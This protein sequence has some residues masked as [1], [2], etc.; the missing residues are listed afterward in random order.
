MALVLGAVLPY[1]LLV[2]RNLYDYLYLQNAGALHHV[3]AFKGSL[4]SA[5]TYYLTG[6]SGETMLG[7]ALYMAVALIALR[8]AFLPRDDAAARWRF[9]ALMLLTAF[10][11]ALPTWLTNKTL[12]VGSP[13]Q[14][15]VVVIAVMCLYALL[16]RL[17]S[18]WFEIA[19][20][21]AVLLT[22]EFPQPLDRR[23]TP[24]VVA[25]NDIMQGLLAALQAQDLKPGEP[26]FLTSTGYVSAN[27]LFYEFSKL[28]LPMP[29]FYELSLSDDASQFEPLIDQ[30]AFVIATEPGNDDVFYTAP[31]AFIQDKT[32][33]MVQQNGAF[34]EAARFST[35]CGKHYYL[36]GRRDRVKKTF[37]PAGPEI[38]PPSPVLAWGFSAP[39][40]DHWRWT[41]RQFAIDFPAPRGLYAELKL[42]LFIPQPNIEKLGPIA[43]EAEIPREGRHSVTFSQPGFHDFTYRYVIQQHLVSTVLVRVRI[44]KSLPPIAGSRDDFGVLFGSAELTPIAVLSGR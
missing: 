3:W 23:A 25:R 22:F 16:A 29:H 24:A 27:T 39:M 32:L 18:A 36:F 37:P 40:P 13:F 28:G 11:Y 15:L 20:I 2:G 4:G 9:G 7:P 31:A 12:T 5:L 34:I 10:A 42:H 41:R 1:Y 33:A 6:F 8:A 43:V 44:N 17:H 26:V 14:F 21:A 19:V 38:T 35:W 30:A